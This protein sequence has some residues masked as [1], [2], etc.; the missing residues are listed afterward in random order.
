[1]SGKFAGCVVHRTFVHIRRN[2]ALSEVFSSLRSALCS[3]SQFPSTQN[4]ALSS[5]LRHTKDSRCTPGAKQ[6]VPRQGCPIAA[7]E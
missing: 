4:S 5:V 3:V 1:M 2:S 6:V 7:P